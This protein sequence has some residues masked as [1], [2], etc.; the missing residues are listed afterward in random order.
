MSTKQGTLNNLLTSHNNGENP[1]FSQKIN[2]Q[3]NSSIPSRKNQKIN[4]PQIR[5]KKP[6]FNQLKKKLEFISISSRNLKTSKKKQ[7]NSCKILGE[8][9]RLPSL[10]K[11]QNHYSIKSLEN[12]IKQKILDISAQIEK[13]EINFSGNENNKNNYKVAKSF[14]CSNKL[15]K[16]L[17]N[18]D[19]YDSSSFTQHR[20]DEK[21]K[22]DLF[23]FKSES[24]N[25]KK[26][27]FKGNKEKIF[28]KLEKKRLYMIL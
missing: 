11:K 12:Y 19:G 22:T 24:T 28:R 10:I 27:V 21:R 1:N 20:K 14:I 4:I 18:E 8:C 3:L 16:K 2:E 13:D 9:K 23:S 17:Y 7:F 6:R 15:I 25:N 26:D 5:R